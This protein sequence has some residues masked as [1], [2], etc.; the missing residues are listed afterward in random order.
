MTTTHPFAGTVLCTAPLMLGEGPTF[1]PATGTAWWFNILKRELH[2]L[3]L[4]SGRK[5]VHALPFMGSALAKID[6]GRQL[7]ASDDGLFIR[8]TATGAFTL[9]AELEKDIPGNRSNDGRVH[10]SGALWIGTMGRKAETGAGSIYH[11]A[12]GVVTK[13]FSNVSIPNSICFS[14]D[15]TIGYYTDTKVNKLMKVPLDPQTGLPVGPAEVFVD[16]SDA[17]GGIDGS[18]CDAQGH[19]W[20]ARWGIGAVDRY[21]PDGNHVARYMLPAGQTTCP[22]FIG[23]DAS[24]LL[25]TSARENLDD[26]AVTANPQHGQTFDLGIEVKGVF[27]PAYRL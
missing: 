24:R 17:D 3:H 27:E 20:N 9:H 1:D 26:D 23:P 14:P 2:E 11:V 13:L 4:A 19:I 21:D 8:D 12:K 15:G 6:D 5:T 22:A 18:V 10:P 25:V 7:I 16:S